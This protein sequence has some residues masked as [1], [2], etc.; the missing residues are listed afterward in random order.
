MGK[1]T[2]HEPSSETTLPSAPL[3]MAPSFHVH[4]KKMR[5]RELRVRG[6]L[7]VLSMSW[8]TSVL[9]CRGGEW[10]EGLLVQQKRR[11]AIFNASNGIGCPCQ[12]LAVAHSLDSF[13]EQLV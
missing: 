1:R 3:A 4:V 2:S 7:E 8:V 6:G 13:L 9:R 11:V 10:Q 5:W 12:V